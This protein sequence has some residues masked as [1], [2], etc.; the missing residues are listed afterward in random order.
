MTTQILCQHARSN[1]HPALRHRDTVCSTSMCR[2]MLVEAQLY[3]MA[4][5]AGWLSYNH[6]APPKPAGPKRDCEMA[7]ARQT[8]CGERETHAHAKPCTT[9]PSTANIIPSILQCAVQLYKCA[10]TNGQ[11]DKF[12]EVRP[13][14]K[15]R[16]H[17][18]PMTA[19]HRAAAMAVRSSKNA[20]AKRKHLS[21]VL[22]C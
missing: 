8:L 18:A 20:L 9:K 17:L 19:P 1:R 12:Q 13:E 2:L 3:H 5:R 22:S 21:V 10:P 15:L 11:P 7:R 16:S 4:L 6:A 14:G